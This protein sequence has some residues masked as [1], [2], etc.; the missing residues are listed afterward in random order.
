MLQISKQ[1]SDQRFALRNKRRRNMSS[2]ILIRAKLKAPGNAI[3]I[4]PQANHG[5]IRF[6]RMIHF[7]LSNVIEVAQFC[8]IGRVKHRA[9]AR[10]AIEEVPLQMA[11][12]GCFV[13][14]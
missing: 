1:Q 5:F 11:E 10:C 14:S 4:L 2:K 3:R 13:C 9:K 8:R 6:A 12:V 7:K